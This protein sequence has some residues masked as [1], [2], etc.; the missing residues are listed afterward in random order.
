MLGHLFFPRPSLLFAAMPQFDAVEGQAG[1]A[2]AYQ[3]RRD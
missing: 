1:I 3:R 2:Q